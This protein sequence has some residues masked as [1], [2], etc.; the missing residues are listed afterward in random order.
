MKTHTRAFRS[1]SGN[2]LHVSMATTDIA[3][4]MDLP[5]NVLH[6]FDQ[7]L[8][9][10]KETASQKRMTHNEL[11]LV[12]A[13][14]SS[15][16]LFCLHPLLFQK[17]SPRH[18]SIRFARHMLQRTNLGQSLTTELRR[19]GLFGFIERQRNRDQITNYTT[20]VERLLAS[21]CM[22][23]A[24]VDEAK[25]IPPEAFKC[26][27]SNFRTENNLRWRDDLWGKGSTVYFQ[28]LK[29]IVRAFAIA[30]DSPELEELS[31]QVR[32]TANGADTWKQF[33]ATASGSDAEWLSFF[34]DWT[35]GTRVSRTD[36][37]WMVGALCEWSKL[38]F[39]SA[40]VVEVM[41]CQARQETFADY[42]LRK[43]GGKK[44]TSNAVRL[45]GRFSTF[46]EGTLRSIGVQ[47]ALWPLVQPNDISRSKERDRRKGGPKPRESQSNPLPPYLVSIVEEILEEGE[48]GWPGRCSLFYESY[49]DEH[50][51]IDRIYSPV[52][53]TFF[54]ILLIIPL[55]G[56]QLA[57]FDS[58]E[59]DCRTFNGIERIWADNTA[60]AAKY[61]KHREGASAHDRGY[62]RQ[63]GDVTQPV[64]GIFVNT[65]KTGDPYTIPWEHP[66][67]H[68]RLWELRVWQEKHLPIESP[69]SPAQYVR[70]DE[71]AEEERLASL[72]DI[73][74]LFRLPSGRRDHI[75]GAPPSW[76]RRDQAWQEI[77]LET[78]RRWNDRNPERQ[79]TI[80]KR[81]EKTGQPYRSLY[82][83][84]GL[85][86]AGLTRL[87][88]SGVPLEIL[89]KLVAGHAG[90]VMTLYYLK[91]KPA[92]IHEI[93]DK[94]SQN[95]LALS[96][97]FLDDFRNWSFDEARKN[98]VSLNDEA[99]RAA[100]EQEPTHKLMYSDVTIGVCPFAG[101]RCSDG[102]EAIPGTMNGRGQ[103]QYNAVE[104]GDK[105]CIMCRHFV[106]GPAFMTQL[107][108][109]GTALLDKFDATSKQIAELEAQR[110]NAIA[111][112]LQATSTVDRLR[113]QTAI[114]S[115]EIQSNS[116]TSANLLLLKGIHRTHRLLEMCEK[117][118]V[119]AGERSGSDLVVQDTAPVVELMEVSE[120][121]RSCI[122][123]AASRLF[124]M[125]H[126]G[127][128]EARRN[129]FLD[130]AMWEAGQTPLTFA[131]L[132]AD[133][134]RYG[135]DAF[136]RMIMEKVDRVETQALV[137]GRLTLQDVG[138]VPD[139]KELLS[140][141]LP[142]PLYAGAIDHEPSAP[143]KH[144]SQVR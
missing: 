35:A 56:V 74:P 129:E 1:K 109:F 79:I 127:E 142:V 16:D 102:G 101:T 118:R 53:P 11:L 123:T 73:F 78:E 3:G 124:P 17:S 34:D 36:S 67:V 114:T 111:Q 131:P 21:L 106:T 132:S 2:R 99:V 55:R 58:G 29:E 107:W 54:Q 138:L 7:L 141:G 66:V 108:L 50:G 136:A 117:I 116:L 61:W 115:L 75:H 24:G 96:Q 92:N 125:M 26:W 76:R 40:S 60:R 143:K 64:T 44:S 139:M 19:A 31:G 68:R 144:N 48:Q 39:P 110:E 51:R 121:E 4:P 83:L 128:T 15:K 52:L 86:V 62:A 18:L 12:E 23:I 28:C 97:S 42:I 80:V 100:V 70:K 104:G 140:R 84:H 90:I 89:S 137:E 87:F 9:I 77:M 94:A 72:P 47:E 126:N 112:R 30:I 37:R 122:I 113:H 25:E 20:I 33:R 69:M 8:Q 6:F 10:S 82:N 120:F 32:Q 65:N 46:V 98:V 59:G 135:Q 91:F 27:L 45:A 134:K 71:K 38:H 14:I 5:G 41:T 49:R 133:Q 43:H 57:R 93:L 63:L 105:N 103:Q 95:A 22:A 88:M 81:Q 85:R 13:F 119:G 130:R